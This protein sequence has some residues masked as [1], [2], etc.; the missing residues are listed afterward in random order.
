MTMLAE[1]ST[2]QLAGLVGVLVFAGAIAAVQMGLIDGRRPVF[3]SITALAAAA[4]LGS[5]IEVYNRDVALLSGLVLAVSLI[6]LVR[7]LAIRRD[8]RRRIDHW[9]ARSWREKHYSSR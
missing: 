1:F 4:V 9:V 2:L 5:N 6:V 3:C 8:A 7:K